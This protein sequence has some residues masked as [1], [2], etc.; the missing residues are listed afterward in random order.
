MT[1]KSGDTRL[2]FSLSNPKLQKMKTMMEQDD[3]K[4]KF[5]IFLLD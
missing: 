2:N 1:I 4:M 3:T 5:P